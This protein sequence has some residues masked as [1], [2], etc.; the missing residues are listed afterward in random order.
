MKVVF[1]FI[2]GLQGYGYVFNTTFNNIQL[3]QVGQFYCRRT[4]K[5][6]KVSDKLYN[7]ILYRA[8]LAI[9]GIRTDNVNDDRHWLHW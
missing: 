7:I 8:H 2:T 1:I 9:S 4:P 5:C 3:Y 6:P